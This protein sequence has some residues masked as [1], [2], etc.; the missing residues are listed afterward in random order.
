M[1]F[2][3]P[4][5]LPCWNARNPDRQPFAVVPAHAV[6]ERCAYCGGLTTDGIYVRA[7][8]KSVPFPAMA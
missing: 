3:Q 1:N 8:P 7:D 4:S 5:C 2:N 6:E